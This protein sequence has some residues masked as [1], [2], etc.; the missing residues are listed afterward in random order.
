MVIL[1]SYLL[2]LGYYQGRIFPGVK[3]AGR[4]M[5]GQTPNTASQ[6][7]TTVFQNRLN[8]PLPLS[9][10][11]QNF[12]LNLAA[13]SPISD[14]DQQVNQAYR[15][16]RSGDVLTDFQNQFQALIFSLNFSPQITFK[17]SSLVLFEINRINQV[18]KKEPLDARLIL[19]EELTL[20][21]AEA[22]QQLDN[23]ILLQQIKDYLTLAADPPTILPIKPIPP[24]FT[25]VEAQKYKTLLV[26]VKDK[27]LKLR[28]EKQILTIDQPALFNLLNFDQSQSPLPLDQGNLEEENILNV[29]KLADFLKKLSDQINQP[30]Q[31]AKF[32]FDPQ[33][34]KVLA[35]QPAQEGRKVDLEETLVLLTQA[36]SKSN[37]ASP[38]AEINLP[39]VVTRPKILTGDVNNFGI[40]ELLGAGVSYFKGSI[41]NRI[42]NIKLAT[43]RINGILVAPGEIFSFN[44]ALGD[45]SAATGFKQAYIIKSGR[46]VLDD[47]G[48]VCQVSTT[49]FRAVLNAGLPVKERTA[50]A[51]RV[52]YYEQGFPPGLDATVFDPTV[53]FKF[54][55]N[56]SAYILIQAYT[57]GAALYFDLYGTSDG[58][59]ATLSKPIVSDQ[60]P[61]LPEL[62]QDDPTL[63][64]GTVKQVDWPAWGAKVSFSRTVTRGGKTIIQ[65]A[66]RSDYRPWQ[67][68]YLVGTKD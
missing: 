3:V 9:F 24:K 52:G 68:I 49:L 33:T 38:S 44:R 67:A 46:T 19:G 58:R 23:Q 59:V 57:V 55:N 8:Q 1:Y 18:I 56:T 11:E 47:G 62:R 4:N 64:R 22:G 7:L 29:D 42:Y 35:F 20:I 43:S 31:D 5:G 2:F 21:P 26:N 14:L 17:R 12:T 6:K 13:A 28:Y 16:G 53:D 36:L 25:T 65:E 45:V 41:D 50:H 34:R 54:Q 37:S 40:K 27:P 48:G 10:R 63:P 32:N 15:V 30:T 39:V 51:Y 66:W 61:P 60:T